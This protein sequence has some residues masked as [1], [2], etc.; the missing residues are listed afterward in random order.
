[1]SEP[2]IPNDMDVVVVGSGAAGLV[3]A[4]VAAVGA[5]RVLR[6]REIQEAR[7]H[8][9]DV[10]GRGVGARHH[11]GRAAGVPDNPAEALAYLRNLKPYR[12]MDMQPAK[13]DTRRPLA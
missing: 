13:Q 11:H 9:R 8:E 4:L 7:R 5:L 12:A 10:R 2:G 1:M 3:C 6:R